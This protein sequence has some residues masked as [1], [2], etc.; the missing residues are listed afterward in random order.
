[1][2]FCVIIISPDQNTRLRLVRVVF[3]QPLRKAQ[4]S[5]RQKYY[6]LA[7]QFTFLD[8]ELKLGVFIHF[9]KSLKFGGGKAVLMV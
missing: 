7:F 1:M 8:P 6:F 3:F 4:F 2:H 9:L 5:V